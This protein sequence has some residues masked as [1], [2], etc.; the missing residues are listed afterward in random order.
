[1]S[2]VIP[3]GI[4]QLDTAHSSVTFSV[5][6]M[7]VAKVRGR[8]TSFQ[9]EIVSA[10]DPARSSVTAT[11]DMASVDTNDAGRDEHLRNND[12]FDVAHHPTMSFVSTGI[13]DAGD[14]YLLRGDLTIK[15]VT[16]PV[17]F[18]LEVGGVGQDPWGNTK[19][20]FTAE[21]TINRKDFGMEYNAA[22]ETGGVLVGDKVSIV[23]DIEAALVT[24]PA[25]AGRA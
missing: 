21:A 3:A 2:P 22:L 24:E 17:T 8:F 11:V 23:L 15:G 25:T 5:R 19:A 13:E 18:D 1:M 16:R 7:M 9:A 12:F 14:G 6:H 4:W 20:G 10:E